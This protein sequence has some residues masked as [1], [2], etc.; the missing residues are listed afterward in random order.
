M[1]TNQRKQFLGLQLNSSEQLLESR[2]R[3]RFWS[4][5]SKRGT[6]FAASFWSGNAIYLDDPLDGEDSL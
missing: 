5:F 2:T 1:V 6:H 4:V 3:W